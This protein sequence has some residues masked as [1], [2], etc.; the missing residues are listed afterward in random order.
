[1]KQ[2][3]NAVLLLAVV[4]TTGVVSPSS[5]QEPTARLVAKEAPARVPLKVTVTISR[6][7]GEKKTASL[8]F[9]LWVNTGG[10]GSIQLG[11]E[12]SIPTTTVKDGVS[13]VGYGYRS[14]GTN[15]SCSATALGDG[16][17]QLSVS[18]EETQ[19]YRMPAL[20][21]TNMPPGN[22][23]VKVLTDPILRDGQ[24]AQF[25][26]A[27]DKTSGEVIKLDVTLNVVK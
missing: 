22:Q 6:F 5:T 27:T 20:G 18:V 12:V 11:G 4:L 14:I 24:T 15:I 21:S 13:S 16:L 3:W 1:M 10:R 23:N 9:V 26:V 7:E 8:P 2:S 19:M 17:Y 25:A